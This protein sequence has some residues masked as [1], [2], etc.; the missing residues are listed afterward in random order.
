MSTYTWLGICRGVIPPFLV[1]R[2]DSL[3]EM[4]DLIETELIAID[5][6]DIVDKQ[7]IMVGSFPVGAHASPNLALLH[8]IKKTQ[9][10]T[11]N[12]KNKWLP[13]TDSHF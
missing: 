6:P 3:E 10:N 9:K 7:V 11:D 1:K 12:R 13:E 2:S 8:T 4:L 5:P